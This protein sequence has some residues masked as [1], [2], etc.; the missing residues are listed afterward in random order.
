MGL[1]LRPQIPEK[2]HFPQNSEDSI[3]G[4]G[5][6]VTRHQRFRRS[7]HWYLARGIAGPFGG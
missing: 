1:G 3:V 2:S 6:I 7:K 5:K 4:C